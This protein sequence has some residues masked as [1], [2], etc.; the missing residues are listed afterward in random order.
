M[1]TCALIYF[2]TLSVLTFGH[3]LH[4]VST[5]PSSSHSSS[6]PVQSS[7]HGSQ[8]SMNFS[9][10]GPSYRLQFFTSCSTGWSTS[11]TGSSSVGSSKGHLPA[12]LLQHRLLSMWVCRAVSL[13]FSVHLIHLLL[14]SSFFSVLT[15]LSQEYYHH[16]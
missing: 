12:N 3:S 10:L 2:N 15:L 7:P 1:Q 4:T 16:H 11:G 14:L 5:T 9:N 8:L 13:M 6:A